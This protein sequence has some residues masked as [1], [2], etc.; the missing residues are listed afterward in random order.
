MNKVKQGFVINLDGRPDRYMEFIQQEFPFKVERIKAIKSR[1][2]E[3]GCTQSHLLALRTIKEFPT[4]VF[5]DDAKMLVAWSYVEKIMQELPVDWDGLWLGVNLQSPLEQ[6]S[7]HLY[8]LTDAYCLH[9]VIY[10]S[11]EMIDYILENHNTPSGKNLDI[12]YHSH[13]FDRFNCYCVSPMCA[14]QRAGVSNI[15]N[16]WTDFADEL[17]ERFEKMTKG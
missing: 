5:E 3:D 12:F 6:Y 11:Q 1:I 16:D 4:V 7:T 13:V 15:C 9:A 8:K 14:T 10:N 2:G 17:Q